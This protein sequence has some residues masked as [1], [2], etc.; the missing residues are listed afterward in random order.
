MPSPLRSV[1]GPYDRELVCG[2]CRSV[3]AFVQIRPLRLARV[4]SVQ[5]PEV[6]PYGGHAAVL[7][8]EARLA[9]AVAAHEESPG[10]AAE[11]EVDAARRR[12][13][14]ARRQ[15]GET[16]VDVECTCGAS[17]LRSMPDIA[18]AV[19]KASGGR[20]ELR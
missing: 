6:Y 10:E 18:K 11:A 19:R 1:F 4:Y 7:D 17:Y 8:A 5:G 15:F 2:R 16:V 3:M 14:Y 13:A 12:V 20:V 9:R